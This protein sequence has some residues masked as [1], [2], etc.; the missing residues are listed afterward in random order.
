MSGAVSGVAYTSS[1]HGLI[2]A[3]KN[4]AWRF[5]DDGI[6]CNAVCPGGVDTNISSSVNM[7]KMDQAAFAMMK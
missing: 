6:R 1:K 7:E 3:T 4:V 2:G 5:Q